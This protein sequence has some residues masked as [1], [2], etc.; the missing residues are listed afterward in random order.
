MKT[1]IITGTSRGLGEA[2]AKELLERNYQ[3]HGLGRS[4]SSGLSNHENYHFTR[5]DFSEP[6][7]LSEKLS[8]V[9]SEIR[10]D[11]PS[12]IGLINS[13]AVTG[14][15]GEIGKL[16]LKTATQTFDICTISPLFLSHL[17]C[18]HFGSLKSDKRI[19]NIS[20]GAAVKAIPGCGV[21]SMAKA[22]LEMNSLA[23]H[24]EQKDK[25]FPVKSF[26]IRPGVIDTGMQKELRESSEKTLPSVGMFRSFQKDGRLKS[27][28]DVA[29]NIIESY[30][31]PEIGSGGVYSVL[32]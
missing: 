25:E 21:Y 17:F 7:T 15:S 29:K 20:S 3:V 10:E 27:P 30:V 18:E 23:I 8:P 2:L 11:N 26:S 32:S 9:F 13:A 31:L 19:L 22:A 6:E 1:Y 14:I 12:E 24:A 16:D 28:K 5:V 4:D